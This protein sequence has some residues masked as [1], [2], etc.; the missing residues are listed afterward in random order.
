MHT[1]SIIKMKVTCQVSSFNVFFIKTHDVHFFASFAFHYQRYHT[2]DIIFLCVYQNECFSVHINNVNV[3]VFYVSFLYGLTSL[4]RL[5]LLNSSSLS[6]L[7]FWSGTTRGILKTSRGGR[8]CSYRPIPSN[9]NTPTPA[10]SLIACI[11]FDA[12]DL[13]RTSWT[14]LS[15]R[16]PRGCHRGRL[17]CTTLPLLATVYIYIWSYY[18]EKK[19][20]KLRK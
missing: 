6:N 8:G 9:G 3:S 7:A 10:C 17:D 11:I 13:Y 12:A 20:E 14:T 5:N 18:L 16:P 19:N 15:P 2:F 1:L 4:S